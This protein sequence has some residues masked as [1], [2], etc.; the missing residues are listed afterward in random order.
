MKLSWTLIIF[1][2]SNGFRSKSIRV[3]VT[4]FHSWKPITGKIM[5]KC[6]ENSPCP[7]RIL[8]PCFWCWDSRQRRQHSL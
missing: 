5:R 7:S 4:S 3:R 6:I 1:K 2:F 8:D